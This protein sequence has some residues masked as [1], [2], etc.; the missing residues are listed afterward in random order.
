MFAGIFVIVVVVLFLRRFRSSIIIVLTIPVSLIVA[1]IFMY[2]WGFTINIFSLMSLAVAIGMVIDNAIVVLEN[3]SRHIEKGVPPMQAAIFGTREMGPAIFA[4]TLT[5]IAVFSPLV[6]LG[7]VVGIMFR[8]LAVITAVT[9]L[10]SLFAALMLTPMLASRLLKPIEE[11][12]PD[13]RL[14]VVSEKAFLYL[15]LQYSRLLEKAILRKWWILGAALVLFGVTLWAGAKSGTDYIPEFDAGDLSVVAETR[16][17]ASTEETLAL[18]RKIEDIFLQEIPEIR[19]LYSLTGQSDQ[20]LLSSVG[21]KEG[22]NVT[23]IFA[24]TVM[25]EYRSRTSA[26]MAEVIREKIGEIPEVENFTVSGGS[27]I[28]AAVL[29]NIRPLQVKITGANLEQLNSLARQIEDTL[30]L[31][32]YYS[33]VESTVDPGK[34]ELQFLVD[35][36][37]AASL[38]LNK[39]M[40]A[41]QMRQS[42]YGEYA[43]DMEDEIGVKIPVNVRYAPVYR[44]D[45]QAA[46]RIMVGTLTGQLLPVGQV[47]TANYGHSPLEIKRENQQRIVY[48][49]AQPYNISLGEAATILGDILDSIEPEAGV[50]IHLGG[51]IEEQKESFGNL[52][53][54]FAIGFVL[55]FM[56]MASQFES[57]R[58]PFVI[59]FTIPFSL[60]GVVLAFYVAGLSLSVVTF[61]GVIMLLGIVV[62][63]GIVLVDYTN[64]L[65]KRGL[66]LHE[67]IFEAGRSRLRPV[68]MTSFTTM[69]GMVPMVFSRG[70]GSEI[71]SPLAITIIGGLFIST[72]ITL[73]LVPVVYLLLNR[74]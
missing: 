53:I 10:A 4:A 67:A 27:L 56:V 11:A 52:W 45:P 37:R 9:L 47:A 55:V 71:W 7:G 26:E 58:H 64:L 12:K 23:T 24:R 33:N 1:F 22:K 42:I 34:P 60:T 16:V 19:N 20:G 6:F 48:V 21:F 59:L 25:P 74:G 3:I 63:N 13:N 43:G 18:T 17:G 57:L 40:V 66:M 69:L 65:R 35:N 72:F 50:R 29:G 46:E 15:E 73:F 62:N 54:M 49:S 30:L 70:I 31:L 51:Q 39:A 28:S 8:Q 2:I 14:L 61:L 5:T 38:G 41:L 32:P 36:Q 68:L 44:N